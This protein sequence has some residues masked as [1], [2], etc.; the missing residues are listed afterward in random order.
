[1]SSAE[2]RLCGQCPYFDRFGVDKK[3]VGVGMVKSSSED[4]STQ[5]I[6]KGFC[7]APYYPFGLTLGIL[8]EKSACRHPVLRNQELPVSEFQDISAGTK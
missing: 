5:E 4:G 1:M 3:P 2:S 7:R 6:K 8:Q